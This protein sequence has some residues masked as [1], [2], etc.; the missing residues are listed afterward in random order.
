MSEDETMPLLKTSNVGTTESERGDESYVPSFLERVSATG[1]NINQRGPKAAF[2]LAQPQWLMV[3]VL[4]VMVLS[5]IFMVI[6]LLVDMS[7]NQ[8]FIGLALGAPWAIITIFWIVQMISNSRKDNRYITLIDNYKRSSSAK[9][10]DA[11]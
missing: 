4:V 1:M 2:Y 10:Y 9:A 6:A 5:F 7:G 3:G 8:V 11:T